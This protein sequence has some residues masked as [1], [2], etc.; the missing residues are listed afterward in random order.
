MSELLDS[1]A[2]KDRLAACA[3]EEREAIERQ[4]M[5]EKARAQEAVRRLTRPRQFPGMSHELGYWAEVNRCEAC[6]RD[7]I[8]S[9]RFARGNSAIQTFGTFMPRYIRER[10][11][12][13]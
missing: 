12:L 4:A 8:R 7:A 3:R 9:Y 13:R 2:G 1:L 11:Y 6:I 10:G 5:R